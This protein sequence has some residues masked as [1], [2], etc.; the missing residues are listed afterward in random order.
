M[1]RKKWIIPIVLLVIVLL[2]GY[3]FFIPF[4]YIKDPGSI[5]NITVKSYNEGTQ[6]SVSYE[7]SEEQEKAVSQILQ[8]IRC[9]RKLNTDF[10][11]EQRL[12]PFQIDCIADGKSCHVVLGAR[13]TV[14]ETTGFFSE[15]RIKNTDTLT[16]ELQTLLSPEGTAVK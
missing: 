10:P 2:L 4:T 15:C 5:Q 14:Y 12:Y 9:T 6:E 13:G 3:I 7:L 11:I 8:N 1:H 16:K